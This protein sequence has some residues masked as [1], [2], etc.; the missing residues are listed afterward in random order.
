MAT[1]WTVLDGNSLIRVLSRKVVQ[2]ADEDTASGVEPG[3]PLD[4]SSTTNRSAVLVAK[5]VA[6]TRAAVRTAGKP[7]LAVTAS[8]V[9]PELVDATLYL[10]AWRLVNSTPN[11]NAALF[12]EGMRTGLKGMYDEA[13]KRIEEVRNGVNVTPPT[14]PTG[15]DYETAVDEDAESATYNPA[16]EGP[17]RWGDMDG[18]DDEFAA[19][20]TDDTV[21][22][23]LPVDMKIT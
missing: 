4:P 22:T 6:E 9:P 21:A 2:D 7:A 18:T 15:Q 1:N 12:N 3:Q 14:D 20:S 10:A 17:V 5:A 11:L 16:L 23:T 8:S 13:V 19:G